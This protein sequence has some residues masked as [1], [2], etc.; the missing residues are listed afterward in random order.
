MFAY[1]A[2]EI[3]VRCD[4][5]WREVF[6]FSGIIGLITFLAGYFELYALFVGILVTLFIVLVFVLNFKRK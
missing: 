6:V 5:E 2:F 4:W 1:C 3:G